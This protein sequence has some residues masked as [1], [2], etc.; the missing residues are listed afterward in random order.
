VRGDEPV[1]QF[2]AE[3]LDQLDR[4]VQVR[5]PTVKPDDGQQAGDPNGFQEIQCVGVVEDDRLDAL[6]RIGVEHV[7]LDDLLDQRDLF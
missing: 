1:K 4:A 3:A 6:A 5:R 7:A 2:L